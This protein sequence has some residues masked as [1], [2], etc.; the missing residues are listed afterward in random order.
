M[1]L[2]NATTSEVTVTAVSK[3]TAKEDV[4]VHVSYTTPEGEVHAD[5]PM[6]VQTP[7]SLST[8]NGPDHPDSTTSEA[9][10]NRSRGCGVTRTF[11]YEIEDQFGDPLSP[12]EAVTFW[13]QI[14]NVANQNGCSITSSTT[15]CPGNTGP[16][17]KT[18]FHQI[19][20]TLS[21][22]APACKTGVA[23]TTGCTTAAT[24]VC[25]VNGIALPAIALTYRCNQILVDG[26]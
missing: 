15:T 14:T 23:C 11:D 18:T 5:I 2:S 16:C 20:E 7:T 21:I 4:T 24:Q 1:T 26:S 8:L 10:C 3:S 19:G 17:T 25:K 13:D 9:T 6:T 22:C 12:S